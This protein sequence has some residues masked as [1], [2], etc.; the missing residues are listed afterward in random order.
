[1]SVIQHLS[2]R[3]AVM[4]LGK[5]VEVGGVNEIFERALHPYTQAL[6]EAIPIPDPDVGKRGCSGR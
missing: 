1:L 3:I 6:L 4:Y 2:D 5:L